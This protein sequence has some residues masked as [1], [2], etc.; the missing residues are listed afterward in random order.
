MDNNLIREYQF[1]QSLIAEHGEVDS[2]LQLKEDVLESILTQLK[3]LVHKLARSYSANKEDLVQAGYLGIIQAL[4]KYEVGN[5]KFSTFAYHYIKNRMMDCVLESKPIPLPTNASIIL[6]RYFKEKPS[7]LDEWVSNLIKLNKYSF[8]PETIK[9]IIK[10]HSNLS[11]I[12][13]EDYQGVDYMPEIKEDYSK[14]RAKVNNILGDKYS[15]I[16]MRV[17]EGVPRAQIAEELGISRQRVS[18]IYDNCIAK[19][20]KRIGVDFTEIRI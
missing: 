3:P 10:N 9:E 6:S 13:Y 17:C 18:V 19:L 14:F 12:P 11:Y 5:S 15:D 16:V 1:T 8:K 7:N 4:D 2:L 20:R